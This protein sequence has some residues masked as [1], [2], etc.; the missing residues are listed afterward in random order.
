M[1]T[2]TNSKTVF[3]EYS[4]AVKGQ[5]FM[6][7]M[8][9]EHG[10]RQIIGRVF[11]D[12]DKDNKKM[13]YTARDWA[14]NEIFADTKD[15]YAIKKKFIENGKVMAQ[16]IPSDHPHNKEEDIELNTE[17]SEGSERGNEVKE[18]RERKT[19]KEKEQGMER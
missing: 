1:K 17:N 14:G 5:H 16:T 4:T 6:T 11:R 10:K 7:V 13:N 8:Q 15:L 12:W 3:I 2:Q 9:N 18:I 19:S